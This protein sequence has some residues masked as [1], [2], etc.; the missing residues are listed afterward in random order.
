MVSG[1]VGGRYTQSDPIGLDGALNLYGY[2]SQSPITTSDSLGLE[3]D[4]KRKNI[5][6][7]ISKKIDD[8][9]K[10]AAPDCERERSSH[11]AVG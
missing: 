7:D 9:V 11:Q 4:C 6:D 10:I 8:V 3:E 1:G 5:C 2:V